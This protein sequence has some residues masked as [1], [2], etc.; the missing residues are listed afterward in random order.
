MTRAICIRGGVRYRN[1]QNIL[2]WKFISPIRYL[3]GIQ[4]TSEYWGMEFSQTK[5]REVENPHALGM[6]CLGEG[7]EGQNLARVFVTF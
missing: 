7:R 2:L 1:G 4:C 6:R 3:D 5:M